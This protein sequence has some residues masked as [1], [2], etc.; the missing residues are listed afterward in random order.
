ML[1][2]VRRCRRGRRVHEAAI[3][4]RVEALQFLLGF[5]ADERLVREA[6]R[7]RQALRLD[8]REP[9]LVVMLQVRRRRVV[10]VADP[11]F[12]AVA[13]KVIVAVGG[14]VA[15]GHRDGHF[16]LPRRL[17]LNAKHARGTV[18]VV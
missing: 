8:G 3:D 2:Q 4:V 13:V 12:E 15:G 1:Q 14:G 18:I 6:A 10:V 11:R 17:R 5:V 16:L 9:A 7:L